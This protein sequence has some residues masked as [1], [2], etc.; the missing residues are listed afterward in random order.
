MHSRATAVTAEKGRCSPSQTL[1]H[2]LGSDVC[3]EGVPGAPP[4]PVHEGRQLRQSPSSISAKKLAEISGQ[5][6]RARGFPSRERGCLPFSSRGG[7]TSAGASPPPC[8]AHLP[9]RIG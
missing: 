4:E 3:V 6:Q 5:R 7:E 1:V 9:Q 8:S 2:T